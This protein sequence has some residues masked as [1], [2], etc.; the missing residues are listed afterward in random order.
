MGGSTPELNGNG[1]ESV[2]K[3]SQTRTSDQHRN[4]QLA[5]LQLDSKQEQADKGAQLQLRVVGHQVDR[6]LAATGTRHPAQEAAVP[7]VVDREKCAQA[8]VLG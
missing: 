7:S 2:M 1:Q 5:K 4:G 8:N 6:L 3:K